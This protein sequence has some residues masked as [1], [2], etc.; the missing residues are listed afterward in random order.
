[1]R[2]KALRNW[3]Q[4]LLSLGTTVGLASASSSAK[5]GMGAKEASKLLLLSRAAEEVALWGTARECR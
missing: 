4:S 3:Q 1:M 2:F 5:Y